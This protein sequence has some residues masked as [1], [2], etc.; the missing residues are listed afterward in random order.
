MT[1]ECCVSIWFYCW[2]YKGWMTLS[3]VGGVSMEKW[4]DLWAS[5]FE[6]EVWASKRKLEPRVWTKLGVKEGSAFLS[7]DSTGSNVQ[8]TTPK[9]WLLN[10]AFS[11]WDLE[12][13]VSG[14][15]WICYSSIPHAAVI[16]GL[17]A[18]L[19]KADCLYFQCFSR[20]FSLGCPHLWLIFLRESRRCSFL[21]N[22]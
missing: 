4:S 12:K 6:K 14:Q 1:G 22:V 5:F 13:K 16:F 21:S 18:L 17:Q 9:C 3:L 7:L 8:G 11:N 19:F 2:I 15:G 10:M 20:L